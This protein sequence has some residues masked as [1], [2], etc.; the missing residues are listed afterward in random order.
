MAL[1]ESASKSDTAWLESILGAH[2]RLGA[3]KVDSTQSQSEQAHL[4][5]NPDE[6]EQLRALN[7]EYE[8]QYPGLRYVVFVNGR[9]R[10]AV[11]DDMRNRIA[12]SDLKSERAAAIRVSPSR[13][14]SPRLALPV[15]TIDLTVDVPRPCV[16]LPLIEPTNYQPNCCFNS[17]QLDRSSY[18]IFFSNLSCV[19]GKVE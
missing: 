7:E 2:P 12:N 4:Q 18:G 11:M 14:W 8:R 10:S 6:G 17:T 1:A 13:A 5:G 16:K 15:G 3:K 9:S 19:L